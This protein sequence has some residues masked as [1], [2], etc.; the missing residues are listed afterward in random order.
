MGDAQFISQVPHLL[1][2]KHTIRAN[3][4]EDFENKDRFGVEPRQR[5]PKSFQNASMPYSGLQPLINGNTMASAGIFNL[6]RHSSGEPPNQVLN[7][8]LLRT[9]LLRRPRLLRAF[10]VF[11]ATA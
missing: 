6:R 7:D 2:L 11:P 8:E 1:F 9:P 5:P 3:S 4:F 10:A